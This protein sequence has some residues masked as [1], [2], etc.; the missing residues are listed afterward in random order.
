[1]LA[2]VGGLAYGVQRL[3]AYKST[4]GATAAAP[5][6]WPGSPRITPVPGRTTLVMFVHPMCSCTRASLSELT[7]ILQQSAGR[8]DAWVLVLRPQGAVEGWEHNGTWDAARRLQ[9]VQVV[10]DEDGN[11]AERFHASTSGQVVLY[12]AA[13][14]LQFSG[15]ITGAR[16]H[17]GANAG[18]A[19]VVSLLNE[20]TA[21]RHDHAV[22]GCGLHDPNPRGAEDRAR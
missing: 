1:M 11:E 20:G 19:R 10:L 5:A 22:F 8:V 13:G 12:D 14:D 7:N 6:T 15:G 17:V 9:G 2:W 18:E 21:D 3:W 16:G 4:P